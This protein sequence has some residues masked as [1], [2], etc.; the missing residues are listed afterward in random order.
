MEKIQLINDA[1]IK[2]VLS[3]PLKEERSLIINKVSIQ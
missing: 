2:F 1:N 3:D